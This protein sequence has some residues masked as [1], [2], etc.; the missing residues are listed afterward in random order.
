M[1]TIMEQQTLS[2]QPVSYLV[3]LN[4]GTQEEEGEP[5][6]TVTD[7][8]P[9]KSCSYN[10]QHTGCTGQIVRVQTD[11]GLKRTAP[12]RGDRGQ[13]WPCCRLHSSGDRDQTM[14][15]G[16]LSQMTVMTTSFDIYSVVECI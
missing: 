4:T 3:S 8:F 1:D 16:R 15:G 9:H 12:I 6:P 5:R 10:G 2:F 14:A 13:P 7:R 11:L